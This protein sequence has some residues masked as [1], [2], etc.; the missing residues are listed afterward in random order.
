M[1]LAKRGLDGNT[2]ALF[3]VR[4]SSRAEIWSPDGWRP[5]GPEWTGIG[6]ASDYDPI[7]VEEAVDIL[8][9]WGADELNPVL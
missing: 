2:R 7:T 4:D 6:G 1:F 9:E 3:R 5:A 8:V